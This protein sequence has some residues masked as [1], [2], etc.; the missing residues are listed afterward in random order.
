MG[1]KSGQ[2]AQKDRYSRKLRTVSKW[3]YG[4]IHKILYQVYIVAARDCACDEEHILLHILLSISIETA[5]S[6]DHRYKYGGCVV[7]L[8]TVL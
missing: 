7:V 5:H 1:E 2:H 4:L 3:W 8:S 6:G